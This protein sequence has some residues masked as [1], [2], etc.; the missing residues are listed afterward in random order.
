M[1]DRDESLPQVCLVMLPDTVS[2]FKTFVRKAWEI[3]FAE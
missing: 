1:C 3:P 2:E